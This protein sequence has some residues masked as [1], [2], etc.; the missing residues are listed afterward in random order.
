M[1]SMSKRKL[2][3]SLRQFGPVVLPSLLLCDFG[4]LNHEIERLEKANARALHLDVM[5]GVFVPNLTY[6][7]PICEACRKATKLPLDVH[8]M[9]QR[10]GDY[11]DQFAA[12]GADMITF[13]VESE[14]KPREV[15]MKIREHGIA[16]GIVINP[17]TPVSAIRD[18]LPLCDAVLVMSVQA[19]FGGQKFDKSVLG[20]LRE[21]RELAGPELLLEMDG[22]INEATFAECV[23]A[24]AE[25]LVVGSAIFREPN[26]DYATAMKRLD[27]SVQGSR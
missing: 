1:T 27:A 13:H 23:Q 4:E 12:A 16:S 5:D 19:G 11:I 7:M 22:G 6:G 10:P 20:K 26:K 9:I 8:L 2:I 18:F 24:G 14:C 17:A 3:S 15:L 25:L 21:L